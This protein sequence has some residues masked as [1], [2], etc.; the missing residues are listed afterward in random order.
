MYDFVLFS[1]VVKF[2]DKLI[3]ISQTRYLS[4]HTREQLTIFCAAVVSFA[5]LASSSGEP[6]LLENRCSERDQVYCTDQAR[7]DVQKPPLV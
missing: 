5:L 4:N 6:R 7:Y 3:K 1:S 2:I